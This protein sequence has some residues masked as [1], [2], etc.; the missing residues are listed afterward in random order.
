MNSTRARER[1]L[2]EARAEGRRLTERLAQATQ[3]CDDVLADKLRYASQLAE[4]QAELVTLHNRLQARQRALCACDAA[5]EELRTQ[6][7]RLDAQVEHESFYFLTEKKSY[8]APLMPP[9]MMDH[10]NYVISINRFVKWL[11]EKVEQAGITVFT[12][13]AVA[14][15]PCPPTSLSPSP[16]SPLAP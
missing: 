15:V 9:P 8:R 16:P 12:G 7:Q 6:C 10:G 11:G 4:A 5:K 1:L 14:S 13:F 3:Q 2:D